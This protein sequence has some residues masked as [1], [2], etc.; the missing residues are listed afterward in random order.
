MIVKMKALE[1]ESYLGRESSTSGE[2]PFGGGGIV[3][4]D[5]IHRGLNNGAVI[6]TL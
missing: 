4:H 6:Y 1:L 3:G 5:S 2:P